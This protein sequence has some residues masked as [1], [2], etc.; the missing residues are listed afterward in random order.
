MGWVVVFAIAC[1]IIC[2]AWVCSV[3]VRTAEAD[4]GSRWLNCLDR[5]NRIFCRHYHRLSVDPLP[6][7]A[8]GPA[9]VVANHVSG[10]DPLLLI[11][12]SRRPLRFV[13]ASEQYHRFGLH[14]L[15]KAVGCIPVD[16]KGRPERAF[17]AA[18]KALE[19]GEVV[20]LFPH[21]RIHLDSDVRRPLKPG[22]VRM[23]QRA[24]CP[25]YPVRIEGVRGQGLVLTSAFLRSRARVTGHPPVSCND[26]AAGECLASVAASIERGA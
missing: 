2:L 16:R 1:A 11:A 13:I 9:L 24:D 3:L 5:L 7:P 21:G 22:F 6:L 17:R 12:A 10:L 15:F 26:K 25:V 18:M 8:T 4:W 19:D 23:A 14:W 20:A